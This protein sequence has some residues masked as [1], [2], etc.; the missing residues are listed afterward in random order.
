[1]R[2]WQTLASLA[3][4][5]AFTGAA[6]AQTYSLAE[7]PL[8]G[9]YFRVQLSLSLAGQMTLQQDGKDVSLKETAAATH[10]FLERVLEAG[11]DG[12]ASRVARL[13]TDAKVTI[14]VADEKLE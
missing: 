12:S 4:V 10:D 7:P 11:A 1:M 8:P 6:N 14:T 5:L 3:V 9:S 2:R 13:Y